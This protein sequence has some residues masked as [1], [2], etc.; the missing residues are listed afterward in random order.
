MSN[1]LYHRR[2]PLF[3]GVSLD[4]NCLHT[5]ELSCQ[6]RIKTSLVWKDCVN[7][8]SSFKIFSFACKESIRFQ[9][10]FYLFVSKSASSR[11]PDKLHIFISIMPISSPNPMFDHLLESSHRDDSNKWSNIVLGQET[12][13][14]MLI[15]I[16]FMRLIWSSDIFISLTPFFTKP[17][18]WPLVRIVLLRQFYQISQT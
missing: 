16:Y 9:L 5:V 4:P 6:N 11:A 17:D 18:V 3:C 10:D 8:N 7:F 14:L 1:N 2:G 13:K 15:E 12:E